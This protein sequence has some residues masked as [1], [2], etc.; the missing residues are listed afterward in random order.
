MM[1]IE[2]NKEIMELTKL[3]LE[4]N[5]IILLTNKMLLEYLATPVVYEKSKAE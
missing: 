3:I 5:R 1:E 4:Q 2:T